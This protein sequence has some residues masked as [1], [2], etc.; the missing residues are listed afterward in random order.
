MMEENAKNLLKRIS[1]KAES[2]TDKKITRVAHAPQKKQWVA[3]IHQNKPH[4]EDI[5]W[6]VQEPHK[7]GD[8]EVHLGFYSAQPGPG[9]SEGLRDAETLANGKVSHIIK[10]ENGIRLVWRTNLNDNNAL[11]RLFESIVSLMPEFIRIAFKVV[12]I[13]SHLVDDDHFEPQTLELKT[14]KENYESENTFDFTVYDSTDAFLHWLKHLELPDFDF[15]YDELY[16]KIYNN[17]GELFGYIE[18]WESNY[19]E[20]I[21]KYGEELGISLIKRLSDEDKNKLKED[22]DWDGES[23]GS[24]LFNIH[25]TDLGMEF[26]GLS[27]EKFICLFEEKK[28]KRFVFSLYICSLLKSFKW[29]LWQNPED[30]PSNWMGLEI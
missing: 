17:V 16:S 21:S 10:N 24:V 20:L 28:I 23:W 14:S 15:H 29:D 11:E 18:D 9:F 26:G 27:G 2:L 22:Y 3:H 7:N 13:S 25:E 5:T 19:S 1:K 12:L 4:W 30:M 8:T 6:R